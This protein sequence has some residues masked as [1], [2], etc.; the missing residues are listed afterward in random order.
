MQ[1]EPSRLLLFC[2]FRGGSGRANPKGRTLTSDSRASS[3]QER[4][5]V[6]FCH[7]VEV[8]VWSEVIRV[9]RVAIRGSAEGSE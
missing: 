7:F 3:V 6:S 4:E 2:I 9:I 8:N 5:E 1:S